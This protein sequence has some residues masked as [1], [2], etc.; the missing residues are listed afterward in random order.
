MRSC[1]NMGSKDRLRK[2]RPLKI[3]MHK[4]AFQTLMSYFSKDDCE[5]GCLIGAGRVLNCVDVVVPVP[6]SAGEE[7]FVPDMDEV[8]RQIA[9]WAEEG[10]CFCGFV[11][12]HPDGKSFL[13]GQDRIAIESWL[14]S[15]DLPLLLFGVVF[16]LRKR[17]KLKLFIAWH[18]ENGEL[19][20]IS[21]H[22]KHQ[23]RRSEF[24]IWRC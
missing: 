16:F 6:G 17:R 24:I 15:S 1:I 21:L 20:I 11:H 9:I 8:N 5:Q 4:A 2:K 23:S 12:S 7:H 3:M 22:R 18:D 10:I 13:S 19:N 14:R